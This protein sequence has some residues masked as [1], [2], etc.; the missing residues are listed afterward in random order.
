[1]IA[2]DGRREDPAEAREQRRLAAAARP[3]QQR[4]LARLDA[5]REPVDRPH[6]VPAARVLDHEVLDLQRGH[7]APP[8]ASAGL[9]VTARRRPG[10]AREPADEHRDERQHDERDSSGSRPA[11]GRSAR[12]RARASAPTSAAIER[13]DDRLHRQPAEQ[14]GRAGAGRLEHREVAH[15]L[16]R[17]EVDHRADDA[18]GDE[19]QQ[20]RDE[21]D[22]LATGAERLQQVLLRLG[23]RRRCAR[24]SDGPADGRGSRSR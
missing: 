11:S 8:N 2:P 3:E 6:R 14:R 24:P 16:Q 7:H 1:M 13:D 10:E 23:D 19:R 12:A 5:H 15:P 4:E 9:T 17:G 20:H 21:V 18:R 22:R